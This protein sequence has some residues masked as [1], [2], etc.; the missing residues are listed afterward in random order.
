MLETLFEKTNFK[1]ILII[2]IAS[3]AIVN[4]WRGTWGLMDTFLFPLNHPLSYTI[5]LIISLIILLLIALHKSKTR[6][7]KK[8]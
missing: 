8:K 5:S 7:Q 2:I 1:D 4:F 6:K 3:L